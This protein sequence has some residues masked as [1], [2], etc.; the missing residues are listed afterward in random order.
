MEATNPSRDT[1]S[2]VTHTA[3]SNVV[4]GDDGA[5]AALHMLQ[6]KTR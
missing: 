4:T 2:S 6:V 3:E 1:A 5:T